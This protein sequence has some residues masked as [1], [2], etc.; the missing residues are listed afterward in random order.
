MFLELLRSRRFAPLFWC[1]FFSAFNDNFVRNM[2]AMLLLFRLGGRESG[3]LI[4][5]AIGIFMLPSI[6][7]SALGGE[8]A[9]AHDKAYVIRRLKAA[10]IL[11]QM[12]AAA[13][14][15]FASLPLLYMALCGLGVIAA[16]FGP[17]KYGILPD[18]LER[19]ELVA[20]NALVEA[21][22]FLAILLGLV[23]G[24]LATRTTIAPIFV[25]LQLMAIALACYATSW[26]IP[27][28]AVAAPHL[29]I[30]AN[31]LASTAAWLGDLRQAH[32]LWRTGLALSWFWL[33]GAVALSLVPVAVRDA[34]GGGIE[35][36]AAISAL[37]ALGIGAGS[38][39]AAF[40][41]RGR[42]LLKPTPLAALGMA[43]FLI[44]IG[45]A[46]HGLGVPAAG[47]TTG[48]AAFFASAEGL[49]IAVDVTGLAAA[50]G[51]YV[52][53]L[54]AAVQ[55]EAPDERRARIIAAINILNAIFMVA[56]TIATAVLQSRLVGL[57]EPLLLIGLGLTNIGA[58]AYVQRE[59]VPHKLA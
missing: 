2:L 32:F 29:K 50:G 3:T 42:I 33:T 22:T 58:A 45:V 21:A 51:A 15:W 48:L 31:V 20:G 52:V 46:T 34:T 38:L 14:F 13:G 49:R 7:L 23:A 35:V 10:E 26:L 25:V 28:T 6:L 4:T 40:F 53:P 55:A 56:G 12:I 44:E 18:Q 8:I 24:A 36:E 39:A 17:I 54:F 43:F 57:S 37:F 59:I 27:A 11:V 5:L 47:H 1:Q 30:K 16:L 9:D 19:H 41:A